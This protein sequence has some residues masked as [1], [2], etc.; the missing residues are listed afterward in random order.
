MSKCIKV[1]FHCQLQC[2]FLPEYGL[3]ISL[4]LCFSRNEQKKDPFRASEP[5]Y[6]TLG[7]KG[8]FLINDIMSNN[9]FEPTT[10]YFVSLADWIKFAFGRVRLFYKER[11]L[12]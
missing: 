11:L 2:K 10:S 12:D 5:N 4:P 7:Y 8:G 6:P 3:F 9:L 1:F